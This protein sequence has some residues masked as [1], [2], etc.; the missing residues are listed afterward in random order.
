MRSALDKVNR[1]IM[2]SFCQYGM[3]DSWNWA[4]EVGGNSWRTTG[5]INDSWGS[6]SEIGFYQQREAPHAVPGHFNDPDML[7]VGKVGWGD[8]QHNTKLTPDEQYTHISLWSLLAS[9]LLIGCDLGHLDRFTL[10]LLTNDEVLAIN[11]DDLGK[12][13]VQVLKKDGYLVYVKEL[14]DGSKA[15]GIFNISDKFQ[16]IT[17]NW[18]DLGISG[19]TKVRD[20]WRQKYLITGNEV[21]KAVV[22]THGVVL[23]RVSK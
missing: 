2:F 17:L 16:T 22:P 10:N 12:E 11:Q 20:V 23:V 4:G 9:P 13:A 18:S 14:Q 5:D 1:D 15:V 3:G 6:M 19:H 7:V 21:F 8:A